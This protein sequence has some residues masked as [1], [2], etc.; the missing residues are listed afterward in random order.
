MWR[1]QGF[2][3]RVLNR[4]HGNA[5][6]RLPQNHHVEDEVINSSTL[7]STSRHS[8]DS[9][10]QRGEDGERRQKRKTSQFCYAGL[11]RYTALDAVG[12]GAA[13]FVFMQVC[14]RLHSQ[15]SSPGEPGPGKKHGG[16]EAVPIA[17]HTC[18]YRVLLD[19]RMSVVGL[20]RRGKILPQGSS[21]SRGSSDSQGSSS[22]SSIEPGHLSHLLRADG[23]Y[24]DHQGAAASQDTK[25]PEESLPSVA[26]EKPAQRDGGEPPREKDQ[27]VPSEEERLAGAALNLQHVAH[28]SVPVVLNIIGLESAA[29]GDHQAAFSCF[30]ASAQRGYAKAQFNTGVCYERGR[31]VARDRDKALRFYS[32]AAAGGH[33]QA[34]YRCAKLLL[35]TRGQHST[36]DLDEAIGLLER[37]AQAGL[38]EAQVYLATVFSQEPVRDGR[39]S[40]HYLQMAAESKNS[41]ALLFLGQCYESGFGVQ[42]NFNKALRFYKQAAQAGNRRAQRLLAT[43]SGGEEEAVLR[44]IRSAPCF[45]VSERLCRPLSSLTS[46]PLL[47]SA[48]PPLPHS[49]STGTLDPSPSSLSSTLLHPSSLTP[50]VD[51]NPCRWTIGVG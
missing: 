51:V 7:L 27:E 43:P 9:S 42:Q 10:S 41:N 30:L 19:T 15:F 38:A 24:S 2:V 11:P 36:Q 3:G 13:A 14:R 17:L 26:E 25:A 12:W 16:L 49:W 40:V 46:G 48:L 21:S 32:Q 44:S 22:S 4:C 33:T 47:T 35:G 50:G 18:G 8:P 39:K 34:Q 23:S 1:V 31:G 6:L 28:S 29:E 45:P 20:G 37:A 5:P